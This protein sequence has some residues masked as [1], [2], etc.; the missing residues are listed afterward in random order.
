M[1]L[2][3]LNLKLQV[4]SRSWH[5]FK[6]GEL[7]SFDYKR[8]SLFAL[9][10]VLGWFLFGYFARPASEAS[11]RPIFTTAQ[12]VRIDLLVE[13]GGNVLYQGE[14]IGNVF[15]FGSE[16]D[17]LSYQVFNRE[18]VAIESLQVAVTLPRNLTSPDDAVA[19]HFG[20]VEVDTSTQPVVTANQVTFR[21]NNLQPNSTYSIE[22]VLPKGIVSP[23]LV[24]ETISSLK[25]IPA[26]IW[27]GASIVLPIITLAILLFY[28]WLA[29]R[30]WVNSSIKEE[31]STPPDNSK[32]AEVGVIVNGRVTA[33]SIAA[34]LIHLATRGFITITR[35]QDGYKFGKRRPVDMTRLEDKF[36]IEPLNQYEA[37]IMDKIFFKSNI[38]SSKEELD[39]RVGHH[40]F[41]RKIAQAYLAI[42]QYTVQNG[43]LIEDPQRKFRKYRLFAFAVICIAIL[44]FVFS[45]LFGPDDNFYYLVGWIGVFLSGILMYQ[46]VPFMP[47]RTPK[48]DK[49]YEEWTK[50]KNYLAS[51]KQIAAESVSAAQKVYE[52]YL[53][54]AIM[55]GVE[56]EWT[57]RFLHLPFFEPEWYIYPGKMDHIE[58][59][60]NSIFPI[61]GQV[62]KNLAKSREPYV[63]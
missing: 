5:N 59:F 34:T 43:W 16:N 57:E 31:R 42:F 51:N 56:V 37:I 28:V 19:R 62:S 11:V 58:Q 45:L 32:P 1:L 41:S 61:I 22:L 38:T 17:T 15:T 33:R 44:S 21:V 48:G 55:F 36:K 4:N 60:A 6:G 8:F 27:I 40:I 2:T 26:P 49:A 30:N 23:G 35:T 10:G 52:S 13:D 47:K 46:I 24:G 9:V 54:Y 50:F 14:S 29:R 3:D 7:F 20:D 39:F 25:A 63:I 18:Q 53:P 12:N